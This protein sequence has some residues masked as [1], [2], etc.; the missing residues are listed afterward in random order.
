[1][2][3]KATLPSSCLMRFRN[4]DLWLSCDASIHCPETNWLPNLFLYNMSA[5][6]IMRLFGTQILLGPFPLTFGDLLY[7]L[8]LTLASPTLPQWE[9]EFLFL[10]AKAWLWY[11][12]LW[13][14]YHRPDLSD[15]WLEVENKRFRALEL[16]ENFS[17]SCIHD[18]TFP[19]KLLIL[20]T[21]DGIVCFR[22]Y[23]FSLVATLSCLS[24]SF[25]KR[26]SLNFFFK[27]KY[28]LDIELQLLSRSS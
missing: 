13:R 4:V 25:F 11:F 5:T 18:V 7:C 22:A 3:P 17:K 10:L 9:Q 20:T 23:T 14:S 1:M 28:C 6:R 12:L 27:F 21:F 15:A 2:P 8:H 16:L 24:V 19:F 26:K